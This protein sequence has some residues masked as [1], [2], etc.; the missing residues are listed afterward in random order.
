MGRTKCPSCECGENWDPKCDT[1]QN[2]DRL[3]VAICDL[4][5]S[6]MSGHEHHWATAIRDLREAMILV[7]S[8][9]EKKEI[10]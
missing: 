7:V 6:K 4:V 2:I 1:C 10:K 3:A 5:Q 9:V 8:P